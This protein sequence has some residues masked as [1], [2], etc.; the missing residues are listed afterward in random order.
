MT[1]PLQ[2]PLPTHYTTPELVCTVAE[3]SLPADDLPPP[4]TFTNSLHNTR[5]GMHS[6]EISLPADYLPPQTTFTNTSHNTRA[7]MHSR[8]I[9]LPADDLPPP[10]TFT[11][12][13]HNTRAGIHSRE[14][15]LPADDLPPP[16]TFTN[17][18]HNTRAGMH[19]REIS[20]PADE[21]PLQPPLPTHYTTSELVCTVVK[22][23]FLLMNSPSSHLYQHI[24][25]HQSWCKIWNNFPPQI[26]F[27]IYRC[28]IDTCYLP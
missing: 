1:F 5:A 7:G 24:T 20:L 4:A 18:S 16:A 12:T 10:A 26:F 13:S 19:S 11:N 14:I 15:S 6:R 22:S 23:V 17:T 8:E 21:L 25:Q 9:S 28:A 27:L 2:P 3:I